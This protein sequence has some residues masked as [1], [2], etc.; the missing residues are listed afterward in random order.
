MALKNTKTKAVQNVSRE[1][2]NVQVLLSQVLA[3]DAA[4]A[5]AERSLDTLDN[6]VATYAA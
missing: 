1:R 6:A 5:S 4:L 2:A 3:T